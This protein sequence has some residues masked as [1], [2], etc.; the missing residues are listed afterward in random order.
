[1]AHAV[2]E[3]SNDWW[4]DAF[5]NYGAAIKGKLSLNRTAMPPAASGALLTN[6]PELS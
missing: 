2:A 6:L 5:V 1:M 4:S 3:S